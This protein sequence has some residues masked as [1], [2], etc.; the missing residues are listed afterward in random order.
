LSI[1]PDALPLAQDGGSI[2][3]VSSVPIGWFM[4]SAGPWGNCELV[5][6][7]DR[8]EVGMHA[9]EC[10]TSRRLALLFHKK[11]IADSFEF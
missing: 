11:N 1:W 4:A 7:L 10:I 5:Q 6:M 8:G 3:S 2:P 9:S